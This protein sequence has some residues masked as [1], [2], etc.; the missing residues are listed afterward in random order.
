MRRAV[1]RAVSIWRA[2]TPNAARAAMAEAERALHIARRIPLGARRASR[3]A[4]H[5][6]RR[7]PA[8]QQRAT[9]RG[10]ASRSCCGWPS[11]SACSIAVEVIPNELSRAGSLV[12][13]V[14]EDLDD[15]GASASASTSATRT[16]TA[17]SS[18][19]SKPCRSTWSPTHVH[20]N[21]GRDRRSPRAV[22]G[23]DRLA[24]GADR[25]AEGRLRRRA[26][27]RDRAARLDRRRRSR[28]REPP[29][30]ADGTAARG[31]DGR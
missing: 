9:P 8:R 23:H 17:T 22:R 6:A 12:H 30:A 25:G 1:G 15:R 3:A 10:A 18:T 7:G 13:F 27:L 2:R 29:R 11:R 4:A 28:G 24:G 16:W 31:C 14:E 20:D 19:R 5:A 26:D 21:R